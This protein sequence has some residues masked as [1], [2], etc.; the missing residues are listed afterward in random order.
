MG[1]SLLFWSRSILPFVRISLVIMLNYVLVVVA[2]VLEIVVVVVMVLVRSGWHIKDTYFPN[3][4]FK[5]NCIVQLCLK[6]GTLHEDTERKLAKISLLASPCLSSTTGE[7]KFS[8]NF[9][10]RSLYKVYRYI[11]VWIKIN[12][13]HGNLPGILC[14]PLKDLA[15]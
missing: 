13:F 9:R 12:D 5:L 1:N 3:A 8:Y 6:Y 11:T 2:V 15:K 14:G 10:L 4:C 7:H